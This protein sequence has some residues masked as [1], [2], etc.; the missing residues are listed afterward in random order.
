MDYV[1]ILGLAC[2]DASFERITEE[3][4]DLFLRANARWAD[5]SESS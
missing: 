3:T 1:V 4:R 5:E 2:A